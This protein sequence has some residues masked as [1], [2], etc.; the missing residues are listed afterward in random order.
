MRPLERECSKWLTTGRHTYEHKLL[1]I[2]SLLSYK[3]ESD[4]ALDNDGGSLG[5]FR[6]SLKKDR[7]AEATP[8]IILRQ[9][10]HVDRCLFVYALPLHISYNDHHHLNQQ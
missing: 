5:R 7:A 6:E 8:V 1:A 4:I 2:E 9:A 3:K 10:T